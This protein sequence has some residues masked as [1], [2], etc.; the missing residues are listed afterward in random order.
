MGAPQNRPSSPPLE[1]A[2]RAQHARIPVKRTLPTRKAFLR[3]TN[4]QPP[5]KH[6]ILLLKHMDKMQWLRAGLVMGVKISAA[7]QQG[8]AL[9]AQKTKPDSSPPCLKKQLQPVLPLAKNSLRPLAALGKMPMHNSLLNYQK[10]QHH[11]NTTHRKAP[12]RINIHLTQTDLY[13]SI[14]RNGQGRQKTAGLAH[15]HAFQTYHQGLII[16]R[17]AAAGFPTASIARRNPMSFE[18]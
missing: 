8:H 4:P 2:P 5:S 13:R 10:K 3:N 18:D 7:L 6:P 15:I 12:N 9:P 16:S 14:H 11:P 17:S 1:T